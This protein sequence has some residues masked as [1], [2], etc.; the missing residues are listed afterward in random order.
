MSLPRP[1]PEQRRKIE[2]NKL[3]NAKIRDDL[4]ARER[5]IVAKVS[6]ITDGALEASRRAAISLPDLQNIID[7]LERAYCL[8]A[9]KEMPIAMKECAMSQARLMGLII[10]RSAV[11]HANVSA[12]NLHG[13]V[14]EQRQAL[15][16]RFAEKH[17]TKQARLLTRAIAWAREHADDDDDMIDVEPDNE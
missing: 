2:A 7:K 4:A 1:S 16:E 15:I 11:M 6:E 10:D 8:A 17:G 3:R 14:D 5:R 13:D 9:A 12:T